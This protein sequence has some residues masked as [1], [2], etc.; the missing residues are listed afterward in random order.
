MSECKNIKTVILAAGHG[1]RMKSEIPKV[2]HKIFS[3]TLLEYVYDS[4]KDFSDENFFIVG[5]KSEIVEDFI[6]QNFE[7]SKAVLQS[8]QLGTGDAVNKA[9]PYLENFQGDVLIL[10][11]DTPLLE[12]ETIEK[13]INFHRQNNCDLSVLSTKVE[14]PFGYGRIVRDENANLHKIVEEKDASEQEKKIQEINSGVYCF[15]WQKMKSGF[16]NLECKNNQNE[17]YLTDLVFWALK[18]KLKACAFEIEDERQILGVNSKKDLEKASSIINERKIDQLLSEGVIIQDSKSVWICPETEIASDTVI[19]PNVYI[20]GKNKIGRNC[21]IGPFS[22]LRGNVEIGDDCKIGNFVELKNAKVESN[23]NIC[24]LSYI[25]DC[26]VGKNVNV[27]AGTIVANYNSITKIKSK[28][29]IADGVSIGS[30]SVIVSPVDLKENC[31]VAASTVVTK[32]VEPNSLVITRANAK[33][34]NNYVKK[35]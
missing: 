1:K 2:L 21:K 14:N 35:S 34:I 22:H 18:N 11:G 10:C 28:S 8:P 32:D 29:T 15:D 16:E 17:Y 19:L 13:F 26:S 33:V 9:K 6:L 25:G 3:K 5:H 31:F 24:H 4:I 27:G 20:E 23:T 12:K 7:N 30:N